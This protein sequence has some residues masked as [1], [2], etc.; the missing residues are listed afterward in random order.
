[1]SYAAPSVPEINEILPLPPA[2]LPAWDGKLQWLEA[3]LA[4]IPPE[5]PSEALINQLAK[6]MVL[7]PATGK[8]MP[9]SPAFSETNF[10]GPTFGSGEACPQSGYWRIRWS[11]RGRYYLLQA[12]GARYFEQGEIMPKAEVDFDRKRMWPL[13][14]KIVKTEIGVTWGLLG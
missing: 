7:D 11:G 1:Y 6:A 12:N 2:K 10:L 13:S 9:G 8:P 14:V 5:K 3:R 4:N